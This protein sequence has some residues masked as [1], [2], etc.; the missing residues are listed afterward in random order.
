MGD[1][2]GNV[3][4]KGQLH[5]GLD[6]SGVNPRGRGAGKADSTTTAP[7]GDRKMIHDRRALLTAALGFLQLRQDPPEA[8]PLR[9]WRVNLYPTGTAH[10]IVV[11]SAWEPTLWRASAGRVGG[12]ERIGAGMIVA[13]CVLRQTTLQ[14]VPKPPV[15]IPAAER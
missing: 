13:A 8:T 3:R 7:G 5:R 12:A 11:A 6:A 1:L 9:R 2:L 15:A 14:E 10:S 4:C